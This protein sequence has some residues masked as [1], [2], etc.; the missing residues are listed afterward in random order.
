MEDVPDI[1]RMVKKL[2]ESIETPKCKKKSKHN[3][4]LI[5]LSLSETDQCGSCM[6]E[7][8]SPVAHFD[9]G[10]GHCLGAQERS[11]TVG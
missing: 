3:Y 6:G 1:V 10:V 7:C 5:N 8:S 4:Q 2:Y 9:L 11:C